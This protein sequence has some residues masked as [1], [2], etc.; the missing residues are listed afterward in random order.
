MPWRVIRNSKKK[1]M[2]LSRGM[3]TSNQNTF[4]GRGM[5]IL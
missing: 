1:E 2:D 3:G 5:N 4:H